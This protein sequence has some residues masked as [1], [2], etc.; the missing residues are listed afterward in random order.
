MT[1]PDKEIASLASS[2]NEQLDENQN[3]VGLGITT[4]VSGV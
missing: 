4:A 1:D 3:Q 2:L